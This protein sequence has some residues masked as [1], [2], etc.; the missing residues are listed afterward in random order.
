MTNYDFALNKVKLNQAIAKVGVNAPVE[1]IKEE[2]VKNGGLLEKED[3]KA[4]VIPT[5][6]IATP[7][8]LMIEKKPIKKAVKKVT[9]K[10]K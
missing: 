6:F 4:E 8:G 7:S 2:Y 9:K 10:T 3:S 1:K 5:P